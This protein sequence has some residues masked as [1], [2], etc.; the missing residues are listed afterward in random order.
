MI[1]NKKWGKKA[2]FFYGFFFLKKENNKI[3]GRAPQYLNISPKLT[4][5]Q[6]CTIIFD[7]KI[8]EM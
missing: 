8:I 5:C 1:Q 2:I 4:K 7:S 6:H 3:E